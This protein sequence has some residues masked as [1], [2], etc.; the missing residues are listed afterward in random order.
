MTSSLDIT[1]IFLVSPVVVEA[2]CCMPPTS[3][4]ITTWDNHVPN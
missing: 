2:R 1:R 4:V 3:F